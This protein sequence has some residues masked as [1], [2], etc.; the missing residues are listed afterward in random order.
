MKSLI[1]YLLLL[2]FILSSLFN[3][4][5]NLLKDVPPIHKLQLN[6]LN[7]G[8][9]NLLF[10]QIDPNKYHFEIQQ[11]TNK[12]DRKNIKEIKEIYQADLVL[13]GSFYSENFE[14]LGLLISN[15]ILL[16]PL[17]KSELM[18]GVFFITKDN[19][20]QLLT[21]NNFIEQQEQL[22]K[23]I[24]FAIQAGPILINQDQEVIADPNNTKR[25]SRTAIGIDKNNN[26]II[27]ILHNSIFNQNNFLTLLEFSNLIKN[28]KELQ[29]LGI[30]SVIN[31]DGGKSTGIAIYDQYFPEIEKVQNLITVTQNN[32]E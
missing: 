6:Q 12:D 14:P 11:N 5:C 27:I 13:N 7:D 3:V 24:S 10:I 25:A 1:K 30:H 18:N 21:Y 16:F 15:Q 20:P 19:I 22:T 31:L 17:F 4:G 8:Q 23:N 32:N 29:N 28:N 2:I 26:I 9:N